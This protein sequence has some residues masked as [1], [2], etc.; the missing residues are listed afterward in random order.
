VTS[1]T[2]REIPGWDG[3]QASSRGRIRSVDRQLRD[4]RHASG[5][6]LTPS[7][8][9]KGYLTVTVCRDGRSSTKAVHVLVA[10]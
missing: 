3:Y 9:R 7:R 10:A 4:G 5:V 6:V 8:N 1:E 2:W